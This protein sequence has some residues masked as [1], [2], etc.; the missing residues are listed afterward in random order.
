VAPVAFGSRDADTNSCR[1]NTALLLIRN[2]VLQFCPKSSKAPKDTYVNRNPKEVAHTK[3]ATLSNKTQRI[4][5][6]SWLINSLST[7]SIRER[8]PVLPHRQADVSSQ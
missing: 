7:G 4:S 6:A 5:D 8:D 3:L 1:Q 2:A